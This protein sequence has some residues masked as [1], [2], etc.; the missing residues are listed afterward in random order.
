MKVLFLSD[1]HASEEALAWVARRGKDYDTIVVGGDLSKGD[2]GEFATRFLD[3]ALSTGRRVIFVHGNADRREMAVPEG[4]E[5]LHGAASK[6]GRFSV[7]GLGGS[8][9]TPFGTPFEMDDGSARSVLDRLGHVD[10]L[11]SHCPPVRTKCDRARAGHVGSAPV[12]EYVE[13]EKPVLVLSGH[14]HES[15]AVDNVGGTTVV[16]AGPLADGCFAEV[17]LDGVVTVELKVEALG[18]GGPARDQHIKPKG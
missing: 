9:L 1:V 4:V 16:N 3:G 17:G 6:L 8:N 13:Q 10:I 18:A 14:V 11:V 5:S 2:S 12:R 15:R 7:G